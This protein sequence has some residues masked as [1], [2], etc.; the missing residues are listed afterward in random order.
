MSQQTTLS[1][2]RQRNGL[3]TMHEPS[4]TCCFTGHRPSKL[5]FGYD[6]EH[7]DCLRLKVMLLCEIDRLRGEGVNVFL[8]GMAQGV[9]IFAAEAVLDIRK[10][11]PEV[12]LV[13]V[14]PFEGQADRWS[15]EY[16]ERYF[17]I[18]AQAD[19]VITLRTRYAEGCLWERNRTMVDASSHL[20][21][22][23]GGGA[24][25]TKQ[26]VEYARKKG[27]RV[28][29]IDPVTMKRSRME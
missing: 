19:E 26:T 3:S 28:M 9:D 1:R 16:R 14:V 27:L 17:T 6:E 22:V 18:L 4:K 10:A 13:A 11:Y 2:I 29:V 8:S 25:G 15:P 23:W 12:R 7:P 21:A 5:P 20:V 24:G